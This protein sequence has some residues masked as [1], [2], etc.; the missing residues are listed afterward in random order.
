MRRMNDSS[1]TWLWV[2]IAVVVIGVLIWWLYG[3]TGSSV[4]VPLPPENNSATT[5][6]SP[7][8]NPTPSSPMQATVTYDG[9]SFSPAQ[10]TVAQGGTVTFTD[11]KGSGMW[12]AS[13]PHP[14]HEGYSGTTRTQHCPDTAGIAFDQ[15]KSGASYTF[16]FQK[17]GTW[18]YHDHRNTSASGEIVVTP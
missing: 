9:A 10:V 1:R 4:P 16:T 11:T 14:T 6:T 18:G 5:E 13:N 12:I 3:Q 8:V 15:C 7:A 17:T 2:A